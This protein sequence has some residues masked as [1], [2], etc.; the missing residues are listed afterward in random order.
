M[1]TQVKALVLAAGKGTRLQSESAGLPKVLRQANGRALL[2]YVLESLDFLPPEDVILV[3]GF[4]REA[5]ISA[6]PRHPYAVQEPQRGTGHAVQC[7]AGL[8][9]GY[10]GHLLVTYGDAPLLRRETFQA[11]VETQL[12]EGS[13]CTLLSAIQPEGG[14]YGRILRREDGSFS[15]IVEARDCTPEQAAVRE[16]NVGSYVFHTPALLRALQRLKT[17]NVQG[18]LYLTDTPALIR[19]DG[20]RV[21]IVDTCSPREMLG[22]NTPEQLALVEKILRGDKEMS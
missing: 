21:S 15:A 18:E 8:L 6:Y 4:G 10:E 20:G 22:V 11:L 3:V 1:N 12:R 2:D 9:E 5:V 14:N 17:D 19:E 13:A 16:V 7:A